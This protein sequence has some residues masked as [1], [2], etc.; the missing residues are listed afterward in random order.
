MGLLTVILQA[1]L[2]TTFFNPIICLPSSPFSILNTSPLVASVSE[3]LWHRGQALPVSFFS[4]SM[5]AHL[6]QQKYF[7][8]YSPYLQP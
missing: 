7:I 2:L 6:V 5:Y 4:V 8:S 3:G 1:Q